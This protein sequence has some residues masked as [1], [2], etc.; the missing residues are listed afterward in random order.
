MA[1]AGPAEVGP[2]V[3][4]STE[5]M[6]GWGDT[7]AS[8]PWEEWNDAG[9]RPEGTKKVGKCPR[10]THTMIVYQRAMQYVDIPRWK[11]AYCNCEQPHEGRPSDARVKGCGQGAR[12]PAW[13]GL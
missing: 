13:S 12:I 4:Y 11:E 3:K 2:D 10:C 5:P 6:P 1:D 9:G 7:V 8:W